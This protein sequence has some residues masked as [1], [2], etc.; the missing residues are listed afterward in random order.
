MSTAY[1][2]ALRLLK[3][4]PHHSEELSRKLLLRGF[5]R[6]KIDEVISK[7]QE[8]NLLDNDA[9]AQQYLDSLMRFKTLGFFGM[10]AKLMQRGIPSQEAENLLSANFPPSVEAEL[11]KRVLGKSAKLPKAKIAQ[12][13]A[14]KGFR[15]EVIRALLK[16]FC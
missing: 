11:G 6:D 7:L 2:K 5:K 13:L 8:E 4:R 1:D 14:A 9:F 10:K 3:I 12:R 16:D 15:S